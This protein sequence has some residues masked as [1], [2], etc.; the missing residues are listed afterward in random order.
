MTI[1]EKLTQLNQEW[2]TLQ[3]KIKAKLATHTQEKATLTQKLNTSN[4]QLEL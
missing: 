1:S 3:T 2:N 4:R